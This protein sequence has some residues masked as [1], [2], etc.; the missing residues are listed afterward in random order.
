[1]AQERP[2]GTLVQAIHDLEHAPS[3][4]FYFLEDG[5]NGTIAESYVPFPDLAQSIMRRA[6]TLQA[7][8]IRKGERVALILPDTREFIITFLGAILAGIIP[9]P[10]YPPAGLIQFERY[11][12]HVGS[13][14]R[15]SEA[16]AVVT[17]SSLQSSLRSME[18]PG[19]SV[20]SS[21]ELDR[22]SGPFR[23]EKIGPD[24]IAFLQFTS[25]STS[26][27]KGVRVTHE[28]IASNAAAIATA[29]ALTTDDVPV[30]WLPLFHDMG[31][32]GF[33]LTPLYATVS[34]R[35][36]PTQMF[37]RRPGSWL[38]MISH[39]RGT[40]S[41][42]P[43][44]A[45]S[46]VTRRLKDDEIA[47]L[48]LSAWRIAGCG[49]EPIRAGDL[50]QF[51]HRLAPAGFRREAL[52]PMYGLAEAT[53]AVT[54]PALG[55]GLRYRAVDRLKLRS[56]QVSA[57]SGG[58]ES[59]RIVNCGP[60][61]PGSGVGIFALDDEHSADPL[62]DGRVGEIRLRGPSVTAG[63][64]NDSAANEAAFT[65]GLFKTGDLG[66]LDDGELYVCGRIKDLIIING[67]NYMPDDIE[68][69]ALTVSG[70]RAA[71]AFQ[72]NHAWDNDGG[73]AKLVM[74]A[75]TSTPD[76][77]DLTLLHRVLSAELGMS[78]DD[79][80]L[81]APRELPKTSSGKPRR[82]EAR[83]MYEAG[84]LRH[85]SRQRR[86]DASDPPNSAERDQNV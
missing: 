30:S 86:G 75:E 45:F 16:C 58:P 38:R 42:V 53:L 10:V 12:A 36:M 35:F 33:F 69:A 2:Y 83:Q 23:P 56:E 25:G 40:I 74:A 61:L 68:R 48:D 41:V 70:V 18:M 60:A 49:A 31:L 39:H 80:V 84:L 11:V 1:M 64:W 3:R 78:I 32:I 24:D 4:G 71:M 51:A 21:E 57:V 15:R 29:F 22:M 46:L 26:L 47:K 27:P 17:T 65:G 67:R 8:G 59:V 28:N 5:P 79:I 44:F 14:V 63:Y 20:L 52:L 73:A 50:E 34:T 62:P 72:T 66:F 7:A 54:I 6:G 9:S 55:T 19:L 13:I 37:L 77:F 82:A 85:G 76:T 43:N 81:V